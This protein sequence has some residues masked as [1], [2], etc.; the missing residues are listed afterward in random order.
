MPCLSLDDI[1]EPIEAFWERY[2]PIGESMTKSIKEGDQLHG[3]EVKKHKGIGNAGT[4]EFA[5]RVN[6]KRKKEKMA[7]L[8]RKKN[9]GKK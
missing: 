9:R 6:K 2:K 1:P 4:Q 3:Q 5:N 8:S 7:K